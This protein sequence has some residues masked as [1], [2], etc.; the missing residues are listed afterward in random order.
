MLRL[1]SFNIENLGGGR[2][3]EA[4]ALADRIAAL[5]PMLRRLDA[6]VLCLQEVNAERPRA[7]APRAFAALDR[8][9]EGTPYAAFH[10]AATAGP[11]GGPA[12]V[13]NLVVLSR[14]AIVASETIRHRHVAAPL[15]RRATATP[16]D[17]APA[18]IE[19][20]RPLLRAA[21]ELPDR[22]RLEILNAHL[23]AATASFVPGR[24][25]GAWAWNSAAAW[26]EGYFVSALK[27]A[28]QALELRL[29]VDALL[30]ADADALIAVCGDL[31]AGLDEA[32][33]RLI[34][35]AEEDTGTGALAGRML[36]PLA[37]SLPGD[38]RF[39]VVH[40]GRPELLDHIL[41]SRALM[42]FYRGIDIHNESLSDELVAYAKVER[43]PASHHAPV[44][45][46]FDVG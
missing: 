28:G 6:D 8:L 45:A 3:G 21:I 18:P 1:A 46:T 17:K 15:Y 33:L 39:S 16:A 40:H 24:K 7:N 41:A 43:S 2:S 26:A 42:G 25:R 5:R 23:R 4:A 13:H 22:R 35:A 34:V 29:I 44:V 12:D 14:H 36:T 32:P 10:R 31:N 30:D 38:R 27:R 37:R 9:L 19:W 20:D 11:K